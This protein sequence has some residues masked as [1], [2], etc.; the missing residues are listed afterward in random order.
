MIAYVSLSVLDQLRRHLV[1]LH[2]D[3]YRLSLNIFNGA[4]IGAHTRH[5]LEFYECL[6]N[7]AADGVIDYDARAR[8]KAIEY[9]LA[10]ALQYTDRLS[11]QLSAT[12]PRTIAQLCLKMS[13]GPDQSCLIP[14]TFAR[15][16]A[17][18]IEHSIHH[19]ALIRIGLQ[20]AFPE[21]EV[22]PDFGIAYSTIQYR[23]QHSLVSD[24]ELICAH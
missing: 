24:V 14:T 17:Y 16:E 20:T 9:D 3:Q 23:K 1:A 22:E 10:Y 15:E 11:R 8:D 5:V 6:L 13:F 19:F 2:P 7:G 21:V 18:L 4:S 12:N